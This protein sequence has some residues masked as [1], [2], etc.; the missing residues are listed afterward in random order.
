MIT[1]IEGDILDSNV[2][3]ISN[4]NECFIVDAGVKVN[5]VK[6]CVGGQK[7]LGIFLT[8]GHFDHIYYLEDYL[9]EFGCTAYASEYAKEYICDADKN[10]SKIF[11]NHEMKIKDLSKINFLCGDGT[12][13]I[14]D[15]EIEYFQL[16]GHSKGDMVFVFEK[17][18]FVGDLIL[19]DSI[20]RIDMYG[21]D[22]NAMIKSLDFLE[23]YDYKIM[24]SGHGSENRKE[25]QDNVVR[26]WKKFLDR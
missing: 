14:G 1:R 6:E 7:V 2:Y 21:G 17:N 11:Y 4:G 15:F 5:V 19:G 25:T 8:H 9:S 26:L 23:N 16:G 22:K 10:L 24:Y 12:I 13:K 3:V 20:G 18:L